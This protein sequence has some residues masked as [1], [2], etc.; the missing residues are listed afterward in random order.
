M[1]KKKIEG[2]IIILAI[3]VNDILVTRSDE[4][5]ISITKAYL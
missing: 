2:D 4:V 3:Y 1:L 5:G